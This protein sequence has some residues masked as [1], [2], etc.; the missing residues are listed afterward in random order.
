MLV[1]GPFHSGELE[2]QARAGVLDEAR[3]VG[4]IIA[5]RLPSGVERFLGRQRFGVAASLDPSGRVWASLLTGPEGF[6]SAVDSRLLCLAAEPREDDPLGP[7]L[8]ARPELGLLVLDPRTRQRMRFNGRGLLSPEGVFLL[9]AQV[10]GNCPKYIQRRRLEPDGEA[11]REGS[12]RVSSTLDP[13]QR[14]TVDGADTFFIASFH[15]EGG[16]DAS[17]RGG[18]PGF[19]RAVGPRTL[20]F[21]DYPGNGMFNTLGNLAAYPQA[22]LL[23]VDFAGGDLLQLTGRAH[24]R[25]DVSVAFEIDEVRETPGGSPLRFAFVEYSPANLP[26]SHDTEPLSTRER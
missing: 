24:V 4:R 5:D 20:L 8:R 23:F 13:R 9:V 14:S 11:P 15:P 16:A 17:H 2:M 3:T 21:P 10:Y 18:H 26:V 7:N 19:V 6:I 1:D 12:T 25:R 22:G